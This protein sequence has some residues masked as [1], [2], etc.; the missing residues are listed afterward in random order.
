MTLDEYASHDACGLASL[1]ARREVSCGEVAAAALA[2]IAALN[3]RLNAVIETFPERATEA[4]PQGPFQGV[5]FLRKDLLIQEEG[6]AVEFGC[7]L[8][9]GY[10][11]VATSEL[12][13]RHRRAGLLT[14]GR[15]TTPELGFNVV[16]ESVLNGATRN[17]WNLERSAGGSSGGAAVAV[18][19]GMT[20]MAH[21]NDGGGS[22]RIPAAS[23]GVV[24]LKPTRGRVPVGPGRGSVLLGLGVEHGLTRTVRDSAALLDA[25][26]GPLAG[27]PFRL[28]T[29]ARPFAE[30]VGAPLACLRIA[31]SAKA[32]SGAP[33]EVEISD[34]LRRGAAL[35]AALGHEV[36]EA[37]PSFDV[38]AFDDATL[39]LW[40]ASIAFAVGRLARG[41]GRSPD[42]NTLERCTLACYDHGRSLSAV[43]LYEAED[44]MNRVSRQVAAFFENHDVLLTP[45]I[46]Q[47]LAPIG[48][49]DQNAA[50]MNARDY[51]QAIFA[52]APFTAVFNATGQP[53]ISLPLAQDSEGLPVGLQFVARFGDEALLLRLAASLEEAA[54]WAD[55]RPA[56]W[57]G[58]LAA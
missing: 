8:A 23:C 57:A 9:R 54:P 48:A 26:H 35:C 28:P 7:R 41:F 4:R 46:A 40:T 50:G 29:I 30:E 42:L 51:A 14:L 56:A 17:P 16:T 52:Y 6:A 49:L 19:S 5:P 31:V 25:T 1:I 53:A 32:W 2:A 13:L 20:P 37:S 55:R 18:A 21:A 22:I 11:A 47:R 34:A 3:P 58:A 15:T 45:T 43:D 10:R 12:A 44:V 24:G 36:V 38:E 39:R 33:V 27:D